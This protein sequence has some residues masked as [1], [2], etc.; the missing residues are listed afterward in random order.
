MEAKENT[1]K[2]IAYS[3]AKEKILYQKEEDIENKF[4]YTN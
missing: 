1:E 2:Q 3:S 4:Y